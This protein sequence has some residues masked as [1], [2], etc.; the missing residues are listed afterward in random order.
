LYD[1]PVAGIGTMMTYDNT[2]DILYITKKDYKLKDGYKTTLQYQSGNVFKK[3]LTKVYLGDPT[4][5]EDV[6]FTISYDVKASVWLSF[7]DWHPTFILPSHRHFMT[8]NGSKIWK[9]NDRC[10]LFCNFYGLDYPFEVEY[11]HSTGQEVAILKSIEYQ[12]ECYKYDNY[13]RDLNHILDSNFDKAIVYN[14][15]QI[16]GM[17]R[18]NLKPKSDPV[19]ILDYPIINTGSID[20]LYS[21]EENK[22]RFNQFYDVTK[23]RG[24]FLDNY[25]PM[26]LTDGNGYTREINDLYVTYTKNPLQHKKFRHYMSKVFLRKTKSEDVKMLFKVSNNK[27]T[28]SFR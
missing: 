17:L 13:C 9:H 27:I 7:H 26:F 6:S 4:Y 3:G 2:N 21:K 19:A 8:S 23:N 15:E 10:D 20:I 14:T 25:Q 11:I 28:K 24:E 1:N 5:F 22:Y 12:L 16:S 18:L